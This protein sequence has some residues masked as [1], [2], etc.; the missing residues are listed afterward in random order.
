MAIHHISTEVKVNGLA[1][2][3]DACKTVNQLPL[4]P[5]P[6]VGVRNAAD[7]VVQAVLAFGVDPDL[8]RIYNDH[9]RPHQ[10]TGGTLVALKGLM[11]AC[12]IANAFGAVIIRMQEESFIE[13]C[14]IALRELGVPAQH[15]DNLLAEYS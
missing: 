3:L 8:V 6:E 9:H 14:V 1:L 15:I 13:E 5:D 10:Y 4:R 11:Y 7:N 12:T 2:L